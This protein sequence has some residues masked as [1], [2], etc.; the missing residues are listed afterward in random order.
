MPISTMTARRSLEFDKLL[1]LRARDAAAISATTSSTGVA[2]RANAYDDFMV[3][4]ITATHTGYAAGTAQWSIQ[5]EV[6]A[7]L[8]SGYQPVGRAVVPDGTAQRHQVAV[9]GQSALMALS[10]TEPLFI[11]VTATKTGS[12][13]NLSYGA[14]VSDYKYD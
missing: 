14:F 5:I 8:S 13:G 2:F 11:R 9:S 12:P 10:G 3:E 6:S 7:S 1:E 4:I